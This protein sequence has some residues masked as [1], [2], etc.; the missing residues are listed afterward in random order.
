MS[1]YTHIAFCQLLV[2]IW[3]PYFDLME[4]DFI[5]EVSKLYLKLGRK[6]QMTGKI[7]QKITKL[8]NQISEFEG[9]VF[10]GR[11]ADGIEMEAR[12][13]QNLAE[14]KLNDNSELKD[15]IEE[16]KE[17][18]ESVQSQLLQSQLLTSH[19]GAKLQSL[20]EDFQVAIDS[21]LEKRKVNSSKR[22]RRWQHHKNRVTAFN[23]VKIVR[24]SETQI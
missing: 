1:S 23:G 11:T 21:I 14:V 10:E 15:K 22:Y 20:V 9:N 6:I 8:V 16:L 3:Y 17:S 5:N 19:E 24:S 13:A 2:K 18:M 12:I 7:D 4:P